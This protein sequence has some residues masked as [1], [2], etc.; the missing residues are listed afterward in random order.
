M[1]Y[2]LNQNDNM[3]KIYAYDNPYSR[4]RIL[5]KDIKTTRRIKIKY[6]HV[7]AFEKFLQKKRARIFNPLKRLLT[8]GLKLYKKH[9]NYDW[10]HIIFS[11]KDMRDN[12]PSADLQAFK[13]NSICVYDILPKEQLS[14]F[15]NGIKRFYYK[16]KKPGGF[17]HNDFRNFSN[18]HDRNQSGLYL[19]LNML[20]DSKNS[21]SK[22]VDTICIFAEELDQAFYVI[23][24]SLIL[25]DLAT[26]KAREIL[27]TQFSNDPLFSV[28]NKSLTSYKKYDFFGANKIE[29][30]N[31]IL[32]IKYNFFELIARY[33]P[34]FFFKRGVI[35]PHLTVVDS[36]GKPKSDLLRLFSFSVFKN[37]HEQEDG[38][39]YD[40]KDGIV[41]NLGFMT[42]NKSFMH[43]HAI[44]FDSV[45]KP[46]YQ[47]L[48]YELEG[49]PV[50][51]GKI[52]VS[53]V[54]SE[55]IDRLIVKEQT[56]VNKAIKKALS[57]QSLLRTRM[58]IYQ[59]IYLY[60]RIEKA[61]VASLRNN[62]DKYWGLDG[63]QNDYRKSFSVKFPYNNGILARKNTLI[64]LMDRQI[65]NID[66][67]FEVFDVKLKLFESSINVRLLR[68]T[69]ILTIVGVVVSLFALLDSAQVIDLA[70]FWSQIFK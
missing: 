1:G 4:Q 27:S 3:D 69:F 14:E 51:L 34:T 26:E 62:N 43:D 15:E 41:C 24:Y 47:Y 16:Y 8:H 22:Y 31:F 33:V 42:N 55:E 2:Q 66:N 25:S 10:L 20:L 70:D 23:T 21:L 64:R 61:L 11:M 29:L 48:A 49:Y 38:G 53:D 39:D 65:V 45:S 18:M 46:D 50:L 32:G 19:L 5:P 35:P 44:I 54:I 52:F 40:Y 17:Q 9:I 56:K 28:T 67:L 60:Q 58:S 7:I 68:W 36:N 6:N 57:T 13:L 37:E 63:F 12:I 30:E 59:N